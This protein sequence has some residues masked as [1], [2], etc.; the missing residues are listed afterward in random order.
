MER[1]GLTEDQ[2]TLLTEA[3]DKE[4]RL[5]RIMESEHFRH[6]ET[7]VKRIDIETLDL[8]NEDL[9]R[10]KLRIEWDGFIPREYRKY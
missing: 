9:I 10:E 2:I 5:R 4:S 1:I 3:L 6:I 8:S 7:I